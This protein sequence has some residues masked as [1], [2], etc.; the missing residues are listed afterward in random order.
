MFIFF[1]S[2]PIGQVFSARLQYDRKR[3]NGDAIVDSSQAKSTI[4]T[5][6]LC[7]YRPS[8][9]TSLILCMCGIKGAQ[10]LAT[11]GTSKRSFQPHHQHKSYVQ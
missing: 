9:S 10:S 4:Q 11:H 6:N 8:M 5:G 3:K 1:L 2:Q 7:Y